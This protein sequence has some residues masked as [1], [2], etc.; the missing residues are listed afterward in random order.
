M[1]SIEIYGIVKKLN[2]MRLI[3]KYLLIYGKE[4]TDSIK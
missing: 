1:I 3:F 4:D 2:E